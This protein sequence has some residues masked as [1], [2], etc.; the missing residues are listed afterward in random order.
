MQQLPVAYT[1]ANPIC[2]VIFTTVAWLE[3]SPSAVTAVH[4]STNPIC[5]AIFSS[6][7]WLAILQ[8]VVTVLQFYKSYVPGHFYFSQLSYIMNVL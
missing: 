2:T 4:N 8:S 1:Y 6:V 3:I 5:T 7:A